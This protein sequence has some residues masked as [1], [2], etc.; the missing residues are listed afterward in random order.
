[1]AGLSSS[2]VACVYPNQAH[3][4]TPDQRRHALKIWS[5]LELTHEAI[6]MHQ[7]QI[8]AAILGTLIVGLDPAVS[9]QAAPRQ[10]ACAEIRAACEQAGFVQGGARTG[11][12]LFV[13]CIAPII[14]Q[15]PQPPRASRPLPK[16][17]L[18][19][20]ADCKAQNPNFGQRNAP[21]SQAAQPPAQS[22]PLPR[23]VTPQVAPAQQRNAPPSQAVV[24]PAS[25]PNPAATPPQ[26]APAP[27]S[28]KTGIGE[29]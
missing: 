10:R 8:W 4:T 7:N 1:M 28:N 19:L 22:S 15:T 3:P 20:V 13:D 29:E 16:I 27:Q 12:G 6:K 2:H 14:R 25:P 21:P 5:A 23:A 24:P 11:D 26:A 17:D 9:V 18:Q